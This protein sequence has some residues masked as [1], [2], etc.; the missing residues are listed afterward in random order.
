MAGDV[1]RTFPQAWILDGFN[2]MLH[3]VWSNMP[4][5]LLFLR[6]FCLFMGDKDIAT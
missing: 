6:S 2:S 5:A 1:L 4:Y 3:D